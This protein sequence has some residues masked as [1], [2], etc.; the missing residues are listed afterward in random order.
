MAWAHWRPSRIA[1]TT[2]DWP[3]RM[4]P[5]ANTFVDRS[6]IGDRVGADIAARVE[7]DAERLD[8]A[9]VHRMHEAHRE[10]HEVGL[11]LELA[12]RDRLNLASTR[13]QCSVVTRPFSPENFVVI[14]A[15][16][17]STPSSWLDEVRSF[18]GHCGQV[19]GLFSFSGGCG[20]ISKLVTDSAPWRIEV[21]MQSEPV[22]PP[23]ITTTCLSVARI[24]AASTGTPRR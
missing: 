24:G 6:L 16:S 3:R 9:F 21:P 10:Q 20:M 2:S 5:A 11:D 13:T 22:S 1:H 12:A 23:P 15:K 7:L 8:H 18:I 19:S 17:R 14:T 4:S